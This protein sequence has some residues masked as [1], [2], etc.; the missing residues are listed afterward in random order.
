MLP[1]SGLPETMNPD[2]H[3]TQDEEI[4][5]SLGKQETQE[6]PGFGLGFGWWFLIIFFC[7]VILSVS[8]MY[9]A[10]QISRFQFVEELKDIYSQ[11]SLKP[12]TEIHTVH[13][14][15]QIYLYY[16][17]RGQSLSAQPKRLPGGREKSS[18][19]L[20]RLILNELKKPTGSPVMESPLSEEVEVGS[21]YVLHGL[22]WLDLS[23]DFEKGVGSNPH[24]QHLIISGLINSFLLNDTTLRGIRFLIEGKPV[25]SIW[26]WLDL[27]NP[28]GPDLSLIHRAGG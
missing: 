8:G 16:L 12:V 15:E 17:I 14:D 26:G 18:H 1:C 7:M 19:E 24:K 22:I 27:S 20:A 23:R 25:D 3:N 11:V 28:L 4:P 9:A 5:V 10:R 6:S 2:H 13:P 21:V